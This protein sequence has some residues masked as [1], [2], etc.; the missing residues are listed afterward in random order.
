[1]SKRINVLHVTSHNEVCGIANYQQQFVDGMKHAQDINN[2]FFGF[3]PYQTRFMNKKQ[4]QNV[5]NEFAKDIKN[6]DIIHIQH[7]LSFYK[8]R[9]EST[10]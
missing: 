5:L 3:S 7:E 6:V 4:Y 2:I 9:L 1:M 10:G 8:H